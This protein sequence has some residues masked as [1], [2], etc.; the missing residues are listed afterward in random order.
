FD[1]WQRAIERLTGKRCLEKAFAWE[2]VE[3]ITG[4]A[5]YLSKWGPSLELTKANTKQGKRGGRTAFQ[6]LR[7]FV[8]HGVVDDGELFKQFAR[9]FAGARQ[10]TWSRDLRKLYLPEPETSDEELAQREVARTE[11]AVP[12]IGAM[13]ASLYRKVTLRGAETE[14]KIAL[15][16]GGLPAVCE[17]LTTMQIPW[18]QSLGPG[19]EHGTYVPLLASPGPSRDTTRGDPGYMP[20]TRRNTH[21]SRSGKPLNRSKDYERTSP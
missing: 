5:K 18:R 6:I 8:D 9:A 13:A 15:Q 19:D 16:Y 10:L 14:L 21:V 3:A 20:R 4:A 1:A 17:L 7:D 11:Q 12:R 2:P